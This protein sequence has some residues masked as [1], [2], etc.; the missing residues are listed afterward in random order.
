MTWT[1]LTFQDSRCVDVLG[2]G[3]GFLLTLV[4]LKS[5]RPDLGASDQFRLY[6]GLFHFPNVKG[7]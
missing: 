2:A 4:I 6:T 5:L 1:L 7:D 3:R